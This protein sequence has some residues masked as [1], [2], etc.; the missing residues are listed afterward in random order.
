MS[1]KELS[2]EILSKEKQLSSI[3]ELIKRKQHQKSKLE[4]NIK[5]IE[6]EILSIIAFDKELKNENQRK[7]VLHQKLKENETY[8]NSQKEIEDIENK[9]IDL[10][11]EKAKLKAELEHLKRLYEIETL[12]LKQSV[13]E[14]I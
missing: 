4:K 14:T 5:E 2:N 1:L 13:E 9:L 6:L 7:A 8:L 12:L 3:E 10:L 11:T